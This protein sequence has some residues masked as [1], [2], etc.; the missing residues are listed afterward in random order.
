MLTDLADLTPP[1]VVC[2]AIIITVVLVLRSQ[3]APK[4]RKDTKHGPCDPR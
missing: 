1:L 2:V 3:M 4:R